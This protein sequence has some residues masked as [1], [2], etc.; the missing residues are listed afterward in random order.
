LKKEDDED[1]ES[2][3]DLEEILGNIMVK[4][5]VEI[6]EEVDANMTD[7]DEV[8]LKAS[9]FLC[10]VCGSEY[11]K[12]GNL[13]LHMKNKHQQEYS[14]I[15]IKCNVRSVGLFSPRTVT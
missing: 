13:N 1:I 5:Q 11:K 4:E 8:V 14:K 6:L 12:I 2:V 10:K 15:E 3:G 7:K 9:A